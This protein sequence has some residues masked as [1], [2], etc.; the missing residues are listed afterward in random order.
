MAEERG[1]DVSRIAARGVGVRAHTM[2]HGDRE[3]VAFER[4]VGNDE[5]YD[6][7][8]AVSERDGRP[9]VVR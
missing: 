1:D 3:R 8:S 7:K 2:V 9:L 6:P 4:A 5:A